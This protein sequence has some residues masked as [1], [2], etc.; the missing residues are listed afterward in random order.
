MSPSGRGPGGGPGPSSSVHPQRG[1]RPSPV[2]TM[3]GPRP[4]IPARP[5]RGA[6]AR[7]GDDGPT[8]DGP[9]ALQIR[10][11]RVVPATTPRSPQKLR[12]P[13]RGVRASETPE[14]SSA[15]RA[16][17]SYDGRRGPPVA[18]LHVRPVPSPPDRPPEVVVPLIRPFRALRYDIDVVGDLGAVVAPPYD[19]L[20][21]HDRQRLNARHPRNVVR[22]D[23]PADEAG[24]ADDD[25]Y[26]RAA[27]TLAAWRSD[28][29]LHKD[30]RPAIYVQEQIYR[31]PGSGVERTQ[32]GFFARLRLEPLGSGSGVLPHERTLETAR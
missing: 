4:R 23:A 19:V 29:T 24:D 7:D 5:P 14:P 15:L 26:R 31:V 20:L 22:L 6:A 10:A 2:R 1:P 9:R 28:G 18:R 16:R 30:P 8:R 11:G 12:E 17:L 32:R 13:D 21:E 27:R 25:R 3:R